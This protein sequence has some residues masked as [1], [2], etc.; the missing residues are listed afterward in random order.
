MPDGVQVLGT[1][2]RDEIHAMN[3]NYTEFKFPQVCGVP[4]SLSV[5]DC[6]GGGA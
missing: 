1:P 4:C 5:R 6:Q 2:S 3:P